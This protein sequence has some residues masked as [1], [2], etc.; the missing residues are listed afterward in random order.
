MAGEDRLL[1]TLGL[2]S[3]TLLIVGSSIGSGIFRLPSQMAAEL[4]SAWLLLAVWVVCGLLSLT[5]ALTFAEMGAMFPRAGG[6]YVFLRQAFGDRVAFLYGWTFFWVIQTGIIAAVAIA[7]SGF[8]GFFV[9]MTLFQQKLLAM[10]VIGLL[11]LVNLVGV[12][13]GSLVANVFT[14]LKV[15]AILALVALGFA[16]A[17]D[18]GGFSRPAIPEGAGAG[19]VGSIGLAM[20]AAFFAYDGWNQSAFVASELK[21]PQRDV[22]R[23]AILG[24]LVVMAVYVLANAVYVHVLPFDQLAST[25]TLAADVASVLLGPVGAA[26]VTLAIVVSTFGTVNAFVMSGPRV[27]YAMAKDGLGYPGMASVSDRFRTPDFAIVLQAEWSMLLVLSGG[28]EDLVNFSVF[29]IWLFYGVAGLGLFLLR[30]RM[31]DAPRPYRTV[32][33]PVVPAVFIAT[34]VFIVVNSLVN[35]TYNAGMGLLLIATGVPAL[36]F[37]EWRRRRAAAPGAARAPPS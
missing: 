26:L 14:A 8:V 3:A 35:D 5:G 12:S 37:L 31:P 13:Y 9:P 25:Q 28:Y 34:S 27:Y 21:N 19:L 33:Y 2:A 4:G 18:A 1:P 15:A 6:Q 16:L 24:V 23:S 36:L 11:S 29:A 20:V 10:A 17:G 32:G 7:F 30:R 22:P